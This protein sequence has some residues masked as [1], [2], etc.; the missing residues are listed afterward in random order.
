MQ[1]MYT[2][3][4]DPIPLHIDYI[5]P[6]SGSFWNTHLGS[7]HMLYVDPQ[8]LQTTSTRWVVVAVSSLDPILDTPA[9]T[10]PHSFLHRPQQHRPHEFEQ[11]KA[12]PIR[13]AMLQA[14]RNVVE[15]VS[16]SGLGLVLGR[17]CR[18]QQAT[19]TTAG[20][21][22][23]SGSPFIQISKPMLITSITISPPCSPGIEAIATLGSP[24]QRTGH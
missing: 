22:D 16:D 24:P 3:S 19:T 20:D 10:P 13:D 1:G 7:T 8:T 17:C 21:E 2:T 6:L 5:L 12:L 9:L 14:P 18:R 15:E 23:Q 11:Y 4:L